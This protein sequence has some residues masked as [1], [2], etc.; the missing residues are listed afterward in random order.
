MNRPAIFV[1]IGG[2]FILAANVLTAAE[3]TRIGS[4]AMVTW[5]TQNYDADRLILNSL[6]AGVVIRAAPNGPI[7]VN[8]SGS[9][10]HL[11]NLTVGKVGTAL[12][13]ADNGQS[14]TDQATIDITLPHQTPI[15]TH[16]LVGS[17]SIDSSDGSLTLET[18][19]AELDLGQIAS[20]VVKTTGTSRLKVDHATDLRLSMSGSSTA[21][22]GEVGALQAHC[23]GSIKIDLKRLEGAADID[24]TGSGTAYVHDGTA[25]PLHVRIIGA[26]RFEMDGTAIDPSIEGAGAGLV[27]LKAYSGRLNTQGTIQVRIGS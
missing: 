16:G 18:T 27:R 26:G 10:E 24:I 2:W 22:L 17:L 19:S 14:H 21:Q 11:A 1:V 5:P 9:A 15:E 20:A 4:V 13:I 7:V 25:N 3:P 23:T 6:V 8:V 12:V